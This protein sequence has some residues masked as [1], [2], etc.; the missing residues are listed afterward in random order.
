M[1]H[2]R[3]LLAVIGIA[4]LACNFLSTAVQAAEK[5]NLI[6]LMADDLGYGDLGCYGQKRIKTP[7]LDRMA[8]EGIRFT[9]HYAGNTVCAPSRCVL[10]TGLHL[11]AAELPIDVR[12]ELSKACVW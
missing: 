5:P 1:H 9:D 4:A 7:S 11:S 6:Y 8:A 3:T 10:M 2:R 12:Q